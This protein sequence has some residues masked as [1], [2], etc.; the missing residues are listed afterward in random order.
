MKNVNDY[1]S[2]LEMVAHCAPFHQTLADDE[3]VT[4]DFPPI[5]AIL[6]L[7]DTSCKP[8]TGRQE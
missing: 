2:L 7:F 3:N 6:M 4:V 8:C 5:F 1:G